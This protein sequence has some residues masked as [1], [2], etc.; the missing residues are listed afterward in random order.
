MKHLSPKHP[1]KISARAL[2]IGAWA[3]FLAIAYRG[4]IEYATTF[5]RH[6]YADLR[7]NPARIALWLVAASI[8][9][10]A[11]YLL[12]RW[13]KDAGGSGIPQVKGF[14][15]GDLPMRAAPVLV[16]RFIGGGLMALF[17]LSMGREGPS[18]HI[19]ATGAQLLCKDRYDGEAEKIMVT[20]GGAAGLA[21]A[22][23]A[24][25][26]G[27]M[28]AL[29]ELHR[30]F[31]RPVLLASMSGAFIAGGCAS[32]I[33]GLRPILGFVTLEY[34]PI[35]DYPWMILLG[36]IAGL[37]GVIMTRGLLGFQT[38]FSYLPGW[39]R[40][41]LALLVALGVG[42]WMPAALGG[43][44]SLIQQAEYASMALSTLFILV[45]V[46]A[47]FTM[48]SFASG[49]PGGIFMPI[50]A[51][52]ALTGGIVG[53]ILFRLGFIEAEAISVFVAAA[54]AG[55]L[56]ASV[57]S[58][59]TAILLTVEMV[60]SIAHLLPVALCAFVALGFSDLVKCPD[61]YGELLRRRV[62]T[63]RSDA[64]SALASSGTSSSR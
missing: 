27:L 29:E 24:P 62:G 25:I 15:K 60:G 36:L 6:M 39:V 22:F 26:S 61:V 63:Y 4:L 34:L 64:Q 54:L 40:I 38:L 50:L 20:A 31:Y 41:F 46:K 59:L 5:S 13:Q 1:W 49:A 21:A 44:E 19:G 30:S 2:V 9:T 52:G 16:V 28:F 48:T 57:K 53:E 7:D 23:S 3:G 55:A 10:T 11:T 14:L 43:G 47:I 33:F 58:P 12:L 51:V 8:F 35:T 17:G 56:S 18:I 42:L 37:A 45:T 32:F